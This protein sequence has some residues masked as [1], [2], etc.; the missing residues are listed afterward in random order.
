MKKRPKQGTSVR[1]KHIN[2]K[3]LRDLEAAIGGLEQKI[4]EISRKLENPLEA[5]ELITELGEKY[6]SL[7]KELNTKWDEWNGLFAD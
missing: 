6:V 4:E 5:S 7:Q 2:P 1:R 3:Q